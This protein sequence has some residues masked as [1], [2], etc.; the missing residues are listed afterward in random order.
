MHKSSGAIG[1]Y[2]NLISRGQPCGE[3]AGARD[4]ALLLLML[5]TSLRVAE[6]CSLRLSDKRWDQNCQ[7]IFSE[8]A[9]RY[10]SCVPWV[11]R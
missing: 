1:R 3:T 10:Q 11:T 8:K 2:L 6:A 7:P 4:Y 5:R 9:V